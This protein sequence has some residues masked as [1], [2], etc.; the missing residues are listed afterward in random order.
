MRPTGDARQIGDAPSALSA[1]QIP[2][3]PKGFRDLLLPLFCLRM[4]QIPQVKANA[5]HHRIL[6]QIKMIMMQ[7][8]DAAFLLVSAA[9]KRVDSGVPG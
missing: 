6:I 8:V 2:E 3:P 7:R 1:K 9:N 5:V 4:E